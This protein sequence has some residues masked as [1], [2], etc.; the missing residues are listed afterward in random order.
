MTETHKIAPELAVTAQ[1]SKEDVGALAAQGFRTL[2]NNRPGGE[3]PGQLSPDEERVKAER[4]GLAYIHIPITLSS[5]SKEDV[6]AFHRAVQESPKPVV[7]H[8]KSG[9]RSYLLWAA[10]EVLS[11]GRDPNELV[12]EAAAA[13]YKLQSLPDLVTRLKS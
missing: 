2:I 7:A 3:E 11:E 9:T 4:H 8:C 13:G 6:E 10:G 12:N 5:V 1:P